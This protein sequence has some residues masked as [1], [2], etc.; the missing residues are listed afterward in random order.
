M[1]FWYWQRICFEEKFSAIISSCTPTRDTK[2]DFCFLF[3][4]IIVQYCV[5]TGTNRK[6]SYRCNAAGRVCCVSK[7][8]HTLTSWPPF[9]PLPLSFPFCQMY[10]FNWTCCTQLVCSHIGLDHLEF[11]LAASYILF[12]PIGRFEAKDLVQFCIWMFECRFMKPA[13]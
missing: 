11:T 12:F 3:V 7:L 8:S 4:F 10:L 2:P 9:L 1:V 5:I 6:W 13:G